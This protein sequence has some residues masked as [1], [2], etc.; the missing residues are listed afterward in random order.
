MQM[1]IVSQCFFNHLTKLNPLEYSLLE[2][3]LLYQIQSA[4]NDY[5]FSLRKTK[6]HPYSQLNPS[7]PPLHCSIQSSQNSLHFNGKSKHKEILM[8][9]AALLQYIIKDI[10]KSEMYT[11]DGIAYYTQTPREVID[12][13]FS[14]ITQSPS[15]AVFRKIIELHLSVRK[16][17]Y[18]TILENFFKT[19]STEN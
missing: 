18:Q 10:L 6:Y 16:S 15:H 14:G 7:S 2:I 5:F 19:F 9:D 1:G 8:K 13:L 11:L 3:A 17:W 12:D 4:L